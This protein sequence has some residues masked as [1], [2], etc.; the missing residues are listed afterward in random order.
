MS[1]SLSSRFISFVSSLLFGIKLNKTAYGS[2]NILAGDVVLFKYKNKNSYPGLP[3]ESETEHLVLVLGSKKGPEGVYIKGLKLNGVDGGT[4]SVVA[5]N[6]Y[7]KRDLDYSPGLASIMGGNNYRTY[8]AQRAW[9]FNEVI[10]DT[11]EVI[12]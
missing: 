5:N 4:A 6:L 8:I 7:K 9:N 11:A 10:L 1:S 3:A 2:A 12:E